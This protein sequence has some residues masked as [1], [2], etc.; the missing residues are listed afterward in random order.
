MSCQVLF[1][2][3][4]AASTSAHDAATNFAKHGPVATAAK[5]W[6]RLC[7]SPSSSLC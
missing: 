5:I 6:V 7:C 1:R 3:S 2:L 4:T